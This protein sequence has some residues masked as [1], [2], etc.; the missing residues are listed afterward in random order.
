MKSPLVDALRQASN[1]ASPNSAE[2]K[3]RESAVRES[4]DNAD[5]QALQSLELD[6]LET[7]RYEAAAETI[8][9][10]PA[11]IDA[12][13]DTETAL[14]EQARTPGSSA[15]N[16]TTFSAGFGSKNIIVKIG[17]ISPFLCAIGLAASAG[18]FL[19][20]ND[21]SVMDQEE[22]FPTYA[23]NDG[24]PNSSQ[25]GDAEEVSLP[26]TGISVFEKFEIEPGRPPNTAD[27]APQPTENKG[28]VA[29]QSTSLPAEVTGTIVPALTRNSDSAVS[30]T[31]YASVVAA[32]KAYQRGDF[33][34]AEQQ[35]DAALEIE[36]N[37]RDGLAGIAAVY[38]QTG[39]KG[40]A[41]VAYER[42]LALD[43]Q[44]TAAA[45]AILAI[46][47][48]DAEWEI[49]SEL[50]LLLQRFPDSHHLHNALGSVYV[51]L[52]RWPEA[53]N[54]FLRAHELAP[55]YADYSYN[56]A[57]SLDRMGQQA[58]AQVYYELALA[59]ASDDSAFDRSAILA[60]RDQFEQR[61]RKRL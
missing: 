29:P 19:V 20:L 50:K 55:D 12:Q 13:T 23:T 49:E 1:D 24:S 45:A 32:Y 42:L 34:T 38:Q 21:L 36:P 53:R 57:V 8:T 25:N 52:G 28:A 5:S 60:H 54:E 11:D 40:S 44:N 56:T 18:V 58:A 39:R 15:Q 46:R 26:T 22:N 31:A 17:R 3:L 4:P 41:A 59:S 33:E 30:D 51:G 37:H 10:T 14:A 47:S 7:G 16:E 6:L 61:Q 48:E 35:Y 27:K 2:D 9:D 43:P